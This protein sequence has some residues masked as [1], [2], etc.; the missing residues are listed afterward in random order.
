MIKTNCTFLIGLIVGI[1]WGYKKSMVQGVPGIWYYPEGTGI[2]GGVRG[3][4]GGVVSHGFGGQ[5]GPSSASPTCYCFFVCVV[6]CCV[7]V[8]VFVA[9]T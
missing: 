6:L 8:C 9:P 2:E 4:G 5:T 3:G 1:K 7:C